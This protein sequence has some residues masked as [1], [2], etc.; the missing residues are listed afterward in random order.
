MGS[1]LARLLSTTASFDAAGAALIKDTRFPVALHVLELL[2]GTIPL[3]AIMTEL[4]RR[5]HS[6]TTERPGAPLLKAAKEATFVTAKGALNID[7]GCQRFFE[8]YDL[9]TTR[10]HFYYPDPVYRALIAG[11]STAS[12]VQCYINGDTWIPECDAALQRAT[13]RDL[14][15]QGSTLYTETDLDALVTWLR[16]WGFN[17]ARHHTDMVNLGRTG[18]PLVLAVTVPAPPAS[19]GPSAS[20]NGTLR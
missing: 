2:V 13:L 15:P 8:A 7:A 14:N 19:V 4:T 5:H 17:Y 6:P 16:A 20:T 12:T 1:R 11:L 10:G 9:V 18:D 3:I